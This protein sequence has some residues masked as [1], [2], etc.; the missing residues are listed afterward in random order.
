M[1]ARYMTIALQRQM[2]APLVRS[3]G[4][5]LVDLMIGIAI[6]LLGALAVTKVMIDFNERRNTSVQLIETQNNG[7]MASYLLERD[8][9]PAGYGLMQLQNCSQIQWYYATTP[10]AN[11]VGQIPLSTLPVSITT[12]G[13]TGSD[14]ITIQYASNAAGVPSA[15]LTQTQATFTDPYNVA[16]IAGYAIGDQIVAD[17]DNVCTLSQVTAVNN[18]SFTISHDQTDPLAPGQTPFNPGATLPN[19]TNPWYADSASTTQATSANLLAKSGTQLI[20][21]GQFVSKRYSVGANVL[22]AGTFPSYADTTLV[23]GIVLLKAQYGRDTGG[24]GTVDVW[25]SPAAFTP[26]NTTAGQVVAIRIGIVARSPLLEKDTI[27]QEN[28]LTILPETAPGAGDAVTYTIPTTASSNHY[29]YKAY[30]TI[31]PLRNVI[32]G[33]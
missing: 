15:T 3:S 17:S 27:A 4:F 13:A 31:V 14:T 18:V 20:N 24:D 1:M 6:G 10:S 12:N 26:N 19:T 29:R 32:W 21:L 22:N 8:L 11:V 16:T 9:G 23:D 28:P 5:S 33:R 30:T 7:V 2:P 25:S